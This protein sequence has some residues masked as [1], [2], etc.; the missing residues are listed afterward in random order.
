MFKV[1]LIQRS[2]WRITRGNY[3]F[4]DDILEQLIDRIVDLVNKGESYL[5]DEDV[6]ERIELVKK[7]AK[8]LISHYPVGSVVTGAFVGYVIARLLTHKDEE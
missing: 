6:Q 8:E 4:M 2:F 1:I 5:K 3:I 7:K